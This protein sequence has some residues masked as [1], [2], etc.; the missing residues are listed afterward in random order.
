MDDVVRFLWVR[1][2]A[3]VTPVAMWRSGGLSLAVGWMAADSVAAL[4]L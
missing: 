3:V 4:V 2:L 1:V